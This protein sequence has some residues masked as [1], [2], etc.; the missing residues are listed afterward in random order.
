MSI[1]FDQVQIK[2][3]QEI[4]FII[5]LFEN[6]RSP[7]PFPGKVYL[8]DHDIL[9]IYLQ[10]DIS[11]Q[12]EAYVVGF[13]LGFDPHSHW[14]H[15][16]LLLIISWFLYPDI[17]KMRPFREWPHFKSGYA[18]AKKMLH[19]DNLSWE[20]I[21]TSPHVTTHHNTRTFYS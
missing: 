18:L 21:Y 15:M 8:E 13:S 5:Q 4:P 17:Y 6:P 2:K 14:I 16:Y 11:A 20:N 10:K 7:L 9:H 19:E 3:P 1:T 12:G